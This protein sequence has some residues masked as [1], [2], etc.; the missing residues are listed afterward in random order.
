MNSLKAWAIDNRLTR[1][2]TACLLA[3][4]VTLNVAC[5]AAPNNASRPAP[6]DIYSQGTQENRGAMGERDQRLDENNPRAAAR[7]RELIDTAKKNVANP[8]KLDD[9]SRQAKESAAEF[10]GQ[11][12][13]GVKRQKD[14]LVKGTERGAEKLK[15][16]LKAASK[17]IPNIVKEATD[18]AIDKVKID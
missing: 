13:D 3:L 6:D 7:T 12:V 17:E 18:G 8:N 14:D 2:L 1:V 16:N 5:A 11:V 4:L 10:P 15:E 9:L